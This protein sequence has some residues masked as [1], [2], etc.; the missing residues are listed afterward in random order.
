MKS[1]KDI[2]TKLPDIA[3]V[4]TEMVQERSKTLHFETHRLTN[5]RSTTTHSS[6]Y[7]EF[8][9][10]GYIFSLCLLPASG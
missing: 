3:S 2:D 7:E 4:L 6:D 9:L 8:Y 10:L 5:S 1:W